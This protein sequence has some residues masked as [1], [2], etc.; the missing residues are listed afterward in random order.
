MIKICNLYPIHGRA[1]DTVFT[2]VFTPHL[3]KSLLALHNH[4]RSC[5]SKSARHSRHD[6][7]KRTRPR[8]DIDENDDSGLDN[9][10][11]R[12]DP[13]LPASTTTARRAD[14]HH[15][16]SPQFASPS[17]TR[18]PRITPRLWLRTFDSAAVDDVPLRHAKP[19]MD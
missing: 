10:P 14:H 8:D 13:I 18:H 3:R 17:D 5:I 4:I 6:S 15:R 1:S 7:N 19:W 12:Q 11:P 16:L 9:H 2:P